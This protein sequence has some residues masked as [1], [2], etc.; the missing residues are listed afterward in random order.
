MDTTQEKIG[1]LEKTIVY[2]TS[3]LFIDIIVGQALTGKP[4]HESLGVKFPSYLQTA[5]EMSLGLGIVYS[6]LKGYSR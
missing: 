3:A 5:E 2:T 1:N 4:L 6:I